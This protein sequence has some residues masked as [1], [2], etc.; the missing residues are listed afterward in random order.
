MHPVRCT[1]GFRG[2]MHSG[3]Q[4]I[5]VLVDPHRPVALFRREALLCVG[6]YCLLRCKTC[7]ML[8]PEP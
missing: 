1:Q 6:L 7:F 8:C 4:G 3:V 5:N 2:F